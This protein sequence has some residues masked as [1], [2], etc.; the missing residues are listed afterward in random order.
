MSR[1]PAASGPLG[2]NWS[3]SLY[4]AAA[5]GGGCFVSAHRR[6]PPR[7]GGPAADPQRA[8]LET[9]GR[10]RGRLRRYS[11]AN[12]LNRLGTLTYGPPRCTDP[13]ELRGHVGEFFRGLRDAL[14]GRPLPY[15]W[16]PEL[17]KDG[18]HLHVH[19][20]V[21]RYVPRHV[22]TTVWGR[23]FVHIKHIGDL[24]VGSGTVAEAR[25]AAGYLSKYVTKSFDDGQR[26][27]F[28]HRYDFAQGFQPEKLR[29]TGVSAEHV[30]AQASEVMGSAPSQSWSSA[31]VEDWQG[32]PAIW[33]QWAA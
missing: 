28:L 9:A 10:A 14:G 31:D 23:G 5:E 13:Q 19:F 2:A 32:P 7:R 27:P 33:L 6:E 18:V 21:G 8:R 4:P 11:A 15:V 12:G 25:K 26:V 30:L 29:L 1:Y 22:I 3:L 17:H 24:P 20:A 16:V